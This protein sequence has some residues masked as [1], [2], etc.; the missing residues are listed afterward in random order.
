M[1]NPGLRRELGLLPATALAI[2]DIVGVGPF[3]TIPVILSAMG[4]P[5]AMLGW[6][7]GAVLA[8]C[9]GLVWAELGAAMPK[10]GGSYNYLREA[11]GPVGAG[12]WFSFLVVWQIMFSAPLSVAS[13]SIGFA[14]YFH[15]LTPGLSPRDVRIF[16][17][18][19]PL[20]LILFLYRRIR[21]VGNLSVVLLG[22]V[23]LGCFWIVGTGLLH[24]KVARVF[25]FPPNAF[26]IDWLF[27]AGLGH[28]TL[29][30]LYDYFGY[31]NVCYLGEEIRDPGRVIPRAIL[32]SIAAVAAL[33]VLMNTSILGVVPWREAQHSEFIASTYIERL[34]GGWAGKL[35]TLLMLWI[36][37]SSVFSLLLGYSRIPY[38]AAVDRNFFRV[39]ARLHPKGDFPHVSLVT[40]GLI[41]S[42]FSLWNLPDVIG[43]LVATR[44]LLQYLPQAIGFF[45]LRFRAPDLERPFRMWFYPLPGVISILGWIYILAT[46]RRAPLIFALSVAAMGTAFFFARAW[47]RREWPFSHPPGTGEGG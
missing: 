36:A 39:F 17:A 3:I 7:L 4:G 32:F 21:V 22:G 44:V 29:I 34:H 28:A 24:L 5:Q 14:K 6:L 46:S 20:V 12:R 26:R 40:L 27:W 25:D 38:A 2:T 1:G 18:A 8:F 13:G 35:I 31:Y 10:A 16:A 30:A 19:V 42:F 9:D 47:T 23:L 37:F 43:S 41:G 33:Y 45:V 15:Y 11:F